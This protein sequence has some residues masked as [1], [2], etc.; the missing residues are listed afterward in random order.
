MENHQVLF[1]LEC[2]IISPG[3]WL[4][5]SSD[6]SCLSPLH[7]VGRSALKPHFALDRTGWAA[8]SV[9]QL[10]HSCRKSLA[11]ITSRVQIWNPFSTHQV[12]CLCPFLKRQKLISAYLQCFASGKDLSLDLLLFYSVTTLITE[13]H[14]NRNS[15]RITKWLN[16]K[17]TLKII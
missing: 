4:S 9:W 2:F 17:G 15:N 5:S 3:I 14:Q 11:P 12:G 6:F 1:H 10:V 13:I 8:G 16:L 7:H